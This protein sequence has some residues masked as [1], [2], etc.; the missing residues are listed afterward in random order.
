MR[1][2]VLVLITGL[3]IA[4]VATA[5]VP[6][7]PSC[8][9]TTYDSYI[10]SGFSCKVNNLKFSNFGLASTGLTAA[11]I[12]LT[13]RTTA[14]NEGFDLEQV[15]SV[16][17]GQSQDLEISFVVTAL[18]GASISDL[19]IDFGNVRTVGSGSVSLAETYCTIDSTCGDFS[20]SSPPGNSFINHVPLANSPIGGPTQQLSIIL[21]VS[22]NGG[23]TGLAALSL[24]GFSFG[25]PQTG[26]TNFG[27][28][29]NTYCPAGSTS[30]PINTATGNY[31]SSHSDIVAPG[32]GLTFN[33][34]RVYNSLDSYSG[35]LGARWT[36]SFNVF[37]TVN[38][39][40]V[41][42]KEADGHTATF[43]PTGGGNYTVATAGVFDVLF[44]NA[45]GT[46]TLTRKNQT[47]FN[48]SSAGMLTTIVDRNG[49][50]QTLTYNGA[51]NLA[52]ILDSSGRT[53][54]FAIDTNGRITS[55]SDPIGRT[56]QYA[57]DANGN[58]I[59]VL[60]AA[61]GTTQYTY[62]A[63]HRM[64]SATDPRGVTFLQNV[65]DSTGRVITQT[66]ARGFAT[67]LAYGSPAP[68]T[69]T[70][71]DPRGNAIEHVYDTSLRL[72]KVIDAKGG[73]ISYA[74][75]GSNDRTSVTNQN[76][77]ATT[78]AYDGN[79]NTTT[80]TDALGNMTT[81]TYDPQNDLLTATNP[82][83]NTTT[84]SYN[85]NG[86][87]TAI[88]DALGDTTAFAYNSAGLA[89][90]K[91]DA[92][93]NTTTFAY[94]TTGDLTKITDVLGNATSLGYD[95]VSRLISVTDAKGHTASSLYDS[96][97][98][99][100]KVTDALGDQTQFAYD[101]VNNLLTLTDANNH[102]T[103]YGYDGTNN[104]VMVT[105]A[106][107]NVTR[108]AYDANNNRTGFTNAKGNTTSYGFDPLNRLNQIIDALLFVTFYQY[109]PVGNVLSTTDANGETNQFS[110]DALNRILSI[111]YA[112][113][114]NVSYGYDADGNRLFMTDPHG[115]TA[116]AYDALERTTSVTSPGSKIVQYAYDAVGNRASL[117]YP[118]GKKVTY[119]YDRVNRL[120]GATDWLGKATNYS[121]DALSNLTLTQYPN[122]A[123]I[124]LAYDAANRLTQVVNSA[125]GIPLLAFNYALDKVGNRLS[126]AVDG[127]TTSFAYDPL[128]ELLSAQLG[129]LKTTWTYDQVGNRLKQVA[130]TGTT[131]YAYDADD[132]LLSA[133]ATNFT[134][135][136][137]G[138]RIT[139]AAGAATQNFSYDAAN[140]LIHVTGPG[141]NSGFTYDGDGNRVAQT[142]IAGTY[143]YV[144]DIN[145][146]LPVVLS[147][148]GPDGAITYAYGSSLIE[149]QVAS[150]NYFY[151][152]DGLGSVIALT[153][154]FG[155]PAAAYAY[156]PW[157]NA[158]LT[159]PD[160]V[161]ERNKF[162]YT[163]QALDPGTG[164]YYL[165]ARYYD[166]V[167]G[168]FLNRDSN[169]G[170][171]VIPLSRNRYTY[172]LSNPLR[173]SDPTGFTAQDT[174]SQSLTASIAVQSS[175]L[176]QDVSDNIQA[177]EQVGLKA[178]ASL[179]NFGSL[180]LNEIEFKIAQLSLRQTINDPMVLQQITDS[181]VSRYETQQ[182][183]PKQAI[184]QALGYSVLSLDTQTYQRLK[185]MF[186]EEL[187]ARNDT[188]PPSS[189]F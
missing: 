47:V 44:Q 132:R 14:G 158:L 159:V 16:G 49:N 38:G 172:G 87:L 152:F 102:A 22:L 86:N 78:F 149:E 165:R 125:F 177:L 90:S 136:A 138:N 83:G 142:T 160:K 25:Q 163:Q 23:P 171:A 137:N 80:V 69:T 20:L 70:F 99:I 33:F 184:E 66:N 134:Y 85:A 41:T 42:V 146:S 124:T 40:S 96:L 50:T 93:G 97:S 15:L 157:G 36:H 60:D 76:G 121:Y 91:T 189:E 175:S 62:D 122:R 68:G 185:E 95:A 130:P 57:Y 128:N 100:V 92:R 52:S 103:A 27:P 3:A 18:N 6:T 73:T 147:E 77:A 182:L 129:P 131:V 112:D 8:P 94:D 154:A 104:L 34:T 84:F 61:G 168:R 118:D 139:K 135:D 51:G 13:P 9:S 140:R 174:A 24:F 183:T 65:F 32:K 98:R 151:H 46:Y 75:D 166:P 116:Y 180:V 43:T 54:T 161:G 114:T 169:G 144:N 178:G 82:K 58:L 4:P 37:L 181:A 179:L 101:P 28:C 153:D 150:S 21:D 123:A 11:Q 88:K 111:A 67:T 17:A 31:Y 10:T 119:T 108:Y 145:T 19:F 188:L 89:T 2:F 12:L 120:A 74:Y 63:S 117:S 81:F 186:I 59:S 187:K 53:F 167:V 106:A 64:T 176:I 30:E 35:P 48:F 133:A 115:T 26:T 7:V 45:D 107:G 127:V 79:G 1:C 110:Y 109:D 5:T 162:R 29:A 39:G 156:D 170:D 72:V 55:V 155:L 105:D 56:W 141:V 173:Y 113:G 143:A 71:T 126:L 164:L 148:Q